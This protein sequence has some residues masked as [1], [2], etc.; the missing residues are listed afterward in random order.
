LRIESGNTYDEE[1]AIHINNEQFR[2]VATKVF[3]ERL[4]LRINPAVVKAMS[5]NMFTTQGNTD[6]ETML[7]VSVI[8]P[9]GLPMREAMYPHIT[10]VDGEPMN[11]LNDYVIKMTKD[12]LPPA[13]AFWSVTLY[14]KANGFFIPNDRKK[15]SVNE[16]AGYKLNDEGGIDIYIAAEKP[17][18]V[19][20]DNWLPIN[21]EDEEIDVILRIYVPDLEKVKSSKVPK[22]E[23][24]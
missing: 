8:G 5:P 7:T 22:A 15:Y 11:A 12:E 23:K 20:D 16:H 14:Y 19:P 17:A 18:G 24:M 2:R 6:L 21:R 3:N 9:I 13:K 10:T 1:T 4:G